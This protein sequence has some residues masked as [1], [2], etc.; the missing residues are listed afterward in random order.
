MSVQMRILKQV[1]VA[2]RQRQ[3]DTQA[4]IDSIEKRVFEPPT[5]PVSHMTEPA[6]IVLEEL[7]VDKAEQNEQDAVIDEQDLRNVMRAALHA[8]DDAKMIDVL[9]V[10]GTRCSKRSRNT[11]RNLDDDTKGA[12]R[13]DLDDTATPEHYHALRRVLHVQHPHGSS[14][15]RTSR[16]CRRLLAPTIT[17]VISDLE[18]SDSPSLPLPGH[19]TLPTVY[20]YNPVPQL[21]EAEVMTEIV[22]EAWVM[23]PLGRLDWH[24]C[25]NLKREKIII[26]LHPHN[27]RGEHATTHPDIE[28]VINI[29]TACNDL[30]DHPQASSYSRRSLARIPPASGCHPCQRAESGNG[31]IAY[32]I[33]QHLGLETPCKMQIAVYQVIQDIADCEVFDGTM[34]ISVD[35]NLLV[36]RGDRNGSLSAFLD[37]L[38]THLDINLTLHEY[39][40]HTID[41]IA[42]ASSLRLHTVLN[43]ANKPLTTAPSPTSSS[44]SASGST[45]STHELI[46]LLITLPM[47]LV[48]LRVIVDDPGVWFFRCILSLPVHALTVHVDSSSLSLLV[49]TDHGTSNE[50][51]PAAPPSWSA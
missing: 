7:Q 37:T 13:L 19:G 51:T 49:R 38:H 24:F 3:Q 5:D 16:A 21:K 32:V 12:I 31:S 11:W 27:D 36:I 34:P 23:V 39:T 18:L 10:S 46:T 41:H 44:S 43:A 25:Q 14:S 29:V 33:Q 35:G 1:L 26:S 9:Q 22:R 45:P 6:P 40:E 17:T 20:K 42:A 8:N 30:P 2:E 48:T 47:S 4:I 15:A 28:T 50:N